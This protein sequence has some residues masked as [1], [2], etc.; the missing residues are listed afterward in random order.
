MKIATGDVARSAAG[1]AVVL[2]MAA[3]AAC[4]TAEP[5]K[6]G[7]FSAEDQIKKI[8]CSDPVGAEHTVQVTNDNGSPHTVTPRLYV[9]DVTGH[10]L[11]EIQDPS[12]APQNVAPGKSV[13]YQVVVPYGE[14]REFEFG[15]VAGV[16]V[17]LE[18]TCS[19]MINVDGVT[20]AISGRKCSGRVDTRTV[21]VY[22]GNADFRQI[23][24][25]PDRAPG[26]PQ[27]RYLVTDR[28]T[29]LPRTAAPPFTFSI[30]ED[31]VGGKRTF[32]LWVYRLIGSSDP[33]SVFFPVKTG[34]Q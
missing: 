32:T 11:S 17:K 7:Y 34:C 23:Q 4:G 12:L 18:N 13:P 21:R 20:A 3:L 15:N 24:E 28:V 22:N 5:A 26:K 25:L 14:F 29:L 1:V 30:P 10:R 8:D 2:M 16:T 31:W 27:D 19:N 33:K 9:T 6:A